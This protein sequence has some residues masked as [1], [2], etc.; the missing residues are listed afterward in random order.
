VARLYANENFPLQAV[1]ELPRLG[2]DVLTVQQAGKSDQAI[3]DDEVLAFAIGET[4]AVVTHN[5]R[6]FIR[7]H[8]QSAGHEGIIVCTVDPDFT[9]LAQR[10]HDAIAALPTLVD[11]LIRINRP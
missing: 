9:A 7:L 2:H 11:L 3:P 10:V 8:E 5:R 4:R 1:E 6:H